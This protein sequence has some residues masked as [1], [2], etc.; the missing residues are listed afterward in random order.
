MLTPQPK[1]IGPRKRLDR[2]ALLRQCV[3][4]AR[5][6]A[7]FE[8]QG[9]FQYLA[10]GP[11][12]DAVCVACREAGNFTGTHRCGFHTYTL[13]YRLRAPRKRASAR[14][15]RKFLDLILRV[16]PANRPIHAENVAR[17]LQL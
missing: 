17:G 2:D 3:R 8:R 12:S 1:P 4:S 5:L 9:C 13:G 10:Y 15:W 7:Y 11:G 14:Q 16:C 6:H